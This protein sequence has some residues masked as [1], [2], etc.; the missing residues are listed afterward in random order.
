MSRDMSWWDKVEVIEK[1]KPRIPSLREQ[2]VE[3]LKETTG[4]TRVVRIPKNKQGHVGHLYAA[5]KRYKMRMR[6]ST[7]GK[8]VYLWWEKP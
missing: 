8:W 4:G 2:A 1:P 3:K 6:S 5:A 7:N